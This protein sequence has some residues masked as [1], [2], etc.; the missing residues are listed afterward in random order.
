MTGNNDMILDIDSIVDACAILDAFVEL[1]AGD[2]VQAAWRS[3]RN[4]HLPPRDAPGD[5]H[6]VDGL[7][8]Q[9]VRNGS[10]V[11]I[12]Y[13]RKRGNSVVDDE[14]WTGI[15]MD[16]RDFAERIDETVADLNTR[17]HL[18]QIVV[19]KL[20]GDTALELADATA[21]AEAAVVTGRIDE[22]LLYRLCLAVETLSGMIDRRG[23]PH[24][25]AVDVDLATASALGLAF[26]EDGIDQRPRCA[27]CDRVLVEDDV[28]EWC[29]EDEIPF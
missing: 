14:L 15:L 22:R 2:G 6:E 25:D 19:A 4:A 13:S 11:G 24:N 3:L 8:R 27:G 20:A 16:M 26:F 5:M 17:L 21:T 7:A 28:C 12:G 23:I 1:N 9:G 18:V 29:D 10:V